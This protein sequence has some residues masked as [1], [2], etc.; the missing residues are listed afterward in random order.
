ML[1]LIAQRKQLFRATSTTLAFAVASNQPLLLQDVQLLTA[2]F[3]RQP[4]LLRQGTGTGHA[5]RFLSQQ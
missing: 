5:M 2:G 1:T 3:T 4:Q